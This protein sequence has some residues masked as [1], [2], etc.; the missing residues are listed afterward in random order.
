MGEIG[1]ALLIMFLIFCGFAI[2]T[3]AE[4]LLLAWVI[5]LIVGLSLWAKEKNDSD[6]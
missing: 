6:D 4:V 1:I 3:I 5:I 2:K